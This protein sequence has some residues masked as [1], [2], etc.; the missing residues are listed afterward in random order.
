MTRLFH[1]SD[2]GDI[3][4]FVPREA[5]SDPADRRLVWAIDEDHLGNQLLPR[6]CPRVCFRAGMATSA[7][8][9]HRFLL[10]APRSHVIAVESAWWPRVSQATLW[11]YDMPTG[12]FTPHD[13]TAGYYV[14]DEP[15]VPRERLKIE[16]V[17]SAL[18]ARGYEL[19]IVPSLWPLRDA[20]IVSTL[21]FSVIRW[22]NAAPRPD[23]IP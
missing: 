21:D 17:P 22:R 13:A 18:M 6:D 8:D 4:S 2:R 19:R 23:V 11:V 14:A 5:S 9:R 3:E 7:D 16:N 20:V 12:S 1:L 10:D 15:V